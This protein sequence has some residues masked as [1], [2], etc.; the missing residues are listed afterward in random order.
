MNQRLPIINLLA[1]LVTIAVNVFS[2]TGLLN[3]T[4]V[5]MVS[6]RYPTLVTPAPYAF[7]IWGVIYLLLAV[8]V[9]SH[10][11]KNAEIRASVAR[12]GWW[13]V[14]SCV[15]NCC[16][17]F[18]WLYEWTGLSVLLMIALL[19]CLVMIVLRTRMELDDP[20]A[21]TVVTLWWPFCIYLGWIMCATLVNVAALLVKTGWT[22]WGISPEVWAMLAMGITCVLYLGLTWWR[23]MREA[24]LVGAWALAAIGVADGGGSAGVGRAAWLFAAVLLVSSMIH[25]YLNRKFAPFRRRS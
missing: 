18:A 21:R 17:I 10:F 11:G 4:T 19:F 12:V 20:P 22:G 16:W 6:A 7:G 23:N 13:F 14:A 8:F 1:L 3:G 9:L 24:A 5:G 25:G 2:N 15:A